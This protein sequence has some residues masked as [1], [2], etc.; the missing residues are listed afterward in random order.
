MVVSPVKSM[1]AAVG[2]IGFSYDESALLWGDRRGN[3]PSFE[4][5]WRE[6][7]DKGQKPRFDRPIPLLIKA[8]IMAALKSVLREKS[9]C[10]S[11][12]LGLTIGAIAA[13]IG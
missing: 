8:V 4:E 12:L 3:I 7:Y 2:E 5:D 9:S 13:L 11:P 1:K 6:S 10:Q